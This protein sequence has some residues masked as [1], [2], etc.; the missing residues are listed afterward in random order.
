MGKGW[1]CRGREQ[2]LT[3]SFTGCVDRV[4]GA[5]RAQPSPV[6]E[7]GDL[8]A[9]D[10][11][12]LTSRL[13]V[14]EQQLLEDSK[15]QSGSEGKFLHTQVLKLP[16]QSGAQ[17]WASIPFSHFPHYMDKGNGPESC[18]T[19]NTSAVSPSVHGHHPS[20]PETHV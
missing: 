1:G 18:T 2:F 16:Q 19:S 3:L 7:V 14:L 4:R 11:Q 17:T 12:A 13:R 9:R 8:E 15:F 10:R 5:T 6:P 20:S